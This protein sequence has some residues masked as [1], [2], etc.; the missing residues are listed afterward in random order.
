[1]NR[2]SRPV[3]ALRPVVGQSARNS[4]FKFVTNGKIRSTKELFF[5]TASHGNEVLVLAMYG[6]LTLGILFYQGVYNCLLKKTEMKL[7]P[8][9][10]SLF[11]QYME[12]LGLDD[13]QALRI[14]QPPHSIEYRFFCNKFGWKDDLKELL[15]EI[16]SFDKPG[17]VM[18]DTIAVPAVL[19]ESTKAMI[20]G[21]DSQP[22]TAS[23]KDA[24]RAAL[25]E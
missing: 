24:L 2:L 14:W 20:L 9:R 16:Y 25:H 12:P 10:R 1:M 3:L 4:Y 22:L 7:Y 6:A 19:D 5:E 18:P 15:R 11:E 8:D 17:A 23:M 13:P 21:K